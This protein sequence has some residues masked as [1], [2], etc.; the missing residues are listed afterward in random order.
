MF[1]AAFCVTTGSC[2][3]FYQKTG[4]TVKMDCAVEGSMTE[5]E[6]KMNNNLVLLRDKTGR[7]RKGIKS[8]AQTVSHKHL[9]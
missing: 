2:K 7:L 4:D 5:L 9:D 6:W 8:F 3:E 1:V